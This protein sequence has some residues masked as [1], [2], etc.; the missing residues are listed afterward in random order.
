MG[1]EWAETP[2]P[3]SCPYSAMP[4]TEWPCRAACLAASDRDHSCAGSSVCAANSALIR[5]LQ[6]C[7]PRGLFLRAAAVVG[8]SC[9]TA[10]G[11]MTR[12]QLEELPLLPFEAHDKGPSCCNVLMSA[13]PPPAP[14]WFAPVHP[15]VF[16]RR[17][18]SWCACSPGTRPQP[19]LCHS[20]LK[21]SPHCPPRRLRHPP[22]RQDD[23]RAAAEGFGERGGSRPP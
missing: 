6:L 19:A 17:L 8:L 3:P 20:D 21:H 9:R 4:G 10:Q 5:F 15:K 12:P 7:L 1:W 11:G 22:H 18:L 23:P 2:S 13:C 14:G 16:P